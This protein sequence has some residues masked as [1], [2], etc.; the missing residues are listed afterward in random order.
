VKTSPPPLDGVSWRG[1]AFGVELRSSF[2]LPGLQALADGTE[3]EPA[4]AP[5][6]MLRLDLSTSAAVERAWSG[7]GEGPSWETVFPEGCFVRFQP[8]KAG[9]HRLEYGGQTSF[10]FSPDARTLLCAPA[11]PADPAWKRF[12][13]DTGLWS[14]S[15]IRGY[16]ALHASAVELPEGVVAFVA[17][18]GGGKTS[19]AA[20]FV[21]C[22]NPLF[23]DDVVALRPT[24]GEVR[25][26]PGPPLMNLALEQS[27]AGAAEIGTVLATFDDEA[28]VAVSNSADEP[29]PLAAVYLLDRRAGLDDA[30]KRVEATV[31]D[32]LPHSFGFHHLRGRR[33]TRFEAFAE[34]AA[35][36]PVF[37]L[38][39]DTATTPAAI[40]H[41]VRRS[42]AQAAEHRGALPSQEAR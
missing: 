28:W 24:D 1:S 2:P 15:L 8:G 36:V 32:L 34:L 16:E 12:L 29:R 7:P 11:D 33:R 35:S 30:V 13:L 38:M 37:K 19:L 17:Q 22:G 3:A 40:A 25:A 23:A 5:D 9:D 31:L 14:V 21:R 26:Y 39:A 42:V 27:R 18:M 20:E 10:H 6:G 4:D 41:L